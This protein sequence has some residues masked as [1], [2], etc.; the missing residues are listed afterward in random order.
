MY[1]DVYQNVFDVTNGGD[2]IVGKS[3]QHLYKYC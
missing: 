1:D 2:G 3:G